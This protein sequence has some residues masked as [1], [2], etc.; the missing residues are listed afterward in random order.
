MREHAA[1][2]QRR[3]PEVAITGTSIGGHVLAQATIEVL[4][5]AGPHLTRASLVAA[6]ESLAGWKSPLC[7]VPA[8]C[9]ASD[10]ALFADARLVEIRGGR[11]API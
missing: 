8:T 4:R 2:M 6:A 10:H 5:R 7:L 3:A 1:L 11:W 9:S